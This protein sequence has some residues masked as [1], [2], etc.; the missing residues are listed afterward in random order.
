MWLEFF[1]IAIVTGTGAGTTGKGG[2]SPAM[3]L[4]ASRFDISSQGPSL[5]AVEISGGD[6]R[7]PPFPLRRASRLQVSGPFFCSFSFL[8]VVR[9]SEKAFPGKG[10]K[11]LSGT[12]PLFLLRGGR[13]VKSLFLLFYPVC[14]HLNVNLTSVVCLWKPFYFFP[15]LRGLDTGLSFS[16]LFLAQVVQSQALEPTPEYLFLFRALARKFFESPWG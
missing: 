5:L 9:V 11:V 4:G 16:L 7:P 6:T 2:C 14:E 15:I 10:W 12:F 1:L 8:L 13:L 3:N